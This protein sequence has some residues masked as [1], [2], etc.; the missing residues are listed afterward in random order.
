MK[1]YIVSKGIKTWLRRSTPEFLGADIPQSNNKKIG[2]G[3]CCPTP[4]HDD[5]SY[6]KT[7]SESRKL[8]A[9][10]KSRFWMPL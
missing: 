5:Y 6:Q 7:L 3:M 8:K 9:G 4:P 1:D 10:S 2:L